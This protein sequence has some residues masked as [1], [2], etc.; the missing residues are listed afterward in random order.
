MYPLSENRYSMCFY[1][2][3]YSTYK[4]YIH[5]LQ[6][7]GVHIII[8]VPTLSYIF[9]LCT[10]LVYTH[11]YNIYIHV[12]TCTCVH[13]Y[14]YVLCTYMCTTHMC[15]HVCTHA[16][17]FFNTVPLILFFYFIK[18]NNDDDIQNVYIS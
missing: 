9:T 7:T 5:V 2:I 12:H 16:Y 6:I 8:T 3:K 15:I 11:T 17:M 1:F 13:V 14:M 10:T 4:N 18:K